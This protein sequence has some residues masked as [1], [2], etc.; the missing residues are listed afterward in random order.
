MPQ[1]Q[2]LADSLPGTSKACL[3]SKRLPATA[4]LGRSFRLGSACTQKSVKWH[5]QCGHQPGAREASSLEKLL[6]CALL[7][8]P[9]AVSASAELFLGIQG[10]LLFPLALPSY[11]FPGH[12]TAESMCLLPVCTWPCKI[13]RCFQPM[14]STE[15]VGWGILMDKRSCFLHAWQEFVSWETGLWDLLRKGQLQW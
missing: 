2:W 14:A 11:S 1:V 9:W 10:G 8:P 7:Q 5:G 12:L 6:P 3:L 13:T 4:H 15:K